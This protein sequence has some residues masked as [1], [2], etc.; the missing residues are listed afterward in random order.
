MAII[1]STALNAIRHKQS[2]HN[3]KKYQNIQQQINTN[4]WSNTFLKIT[5][6]YGEQDSRDFNRL[7]I[8]K[9]SNYANS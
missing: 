7:I 8:D 2:H 9:K 1:R 4:K 5:A 6:G 3:Y